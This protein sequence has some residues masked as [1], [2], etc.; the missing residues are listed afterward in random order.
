MTSNLQI[1]D[2]EPGEHGFSLYQ[3]SS[4]GFEYFSH[5]F[6]GDD[7]FQR[8]G[9][10]PSLFSRLSSATNS[11]IKNFS[12][13]Q[14]R[15]LLVAALAIAGLIL[16]REPTHST[17][18]SIATGTLQLD[19]AT[20]VKQFVGIVVVIL[21]LSVIESMSTSSLYEYLLVSKKIK[22]KM[23]LFVNPGFAVFFL[24]DVISKILG[25]VITSAIAGR[26]WHLRLIVESK[27]EL[28]SSE[29]SLGLMGLQTGP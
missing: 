1:F 7:D 8:V 21:A 16:L 5:R 13:L 10:R 26:I 14:Q 6:E 28:Y 4:K 20:L 2:S 25:I 9:A 22:L 27:N 11:F 23:N 3:G 15:S 29:D 24:S 17:S 19:P 18:F 12:Q